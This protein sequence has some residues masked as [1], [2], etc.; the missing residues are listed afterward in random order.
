MGNGLKLL[1]NQPPSIRDRVDFRAYDFF[2]PQPTP[3]ARVYLLRMILHDWADTDA[4]KILSNVV[5]AMSTHSVLVIMDTVLPEPSRVS[6]TVERIMRVRDLT[7]R[8]VFN[9]KERTLDDWEQ[10]IEGSEKRLKIQSVEQPQQS[11]M[12]LLVVTLRDFKEDVS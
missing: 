5:A 6:S 3:G 12:S 8:Q 1:P 9:S 7:M 2:V 10:L 4:A 11:H